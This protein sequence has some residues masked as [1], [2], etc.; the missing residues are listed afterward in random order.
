[1]EWKPF[2]Q[3]TRYLSLVNGHL[4]LVIWKKSDRLLGGAE[5]EGFGVGVRGE[6]P[7]PALL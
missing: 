2:A 4:S 5:T 7:T 3:G 6:L 1:M